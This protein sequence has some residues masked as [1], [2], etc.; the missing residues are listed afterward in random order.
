MIETIIAG[1]VGGAARILPEVLKL[2]TKKADNKH[3][4]EMLKAEM[5]F[6]RLRGEIQMKQTEAS[7]TMAELDA[8]GKA[9]EEQSNTAAK[10]GW[11]V[12]AISALVRPLVTYWFMVLYSLVKIATMKIALEE[13]YNWKEVVIQNWNGADMSLLTMILSFWFVGRVYERT[14][15]SS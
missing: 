15:G 13:G 10:G 4:L 7:M 11:F 14:K 2:F 12:S 1:A 3:E 8:I 9:F 5:E 6:T